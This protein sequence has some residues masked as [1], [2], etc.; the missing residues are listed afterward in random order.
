MNAI[1]QLGAS[2]SAIKMFYDTCDRSIGAIVAKKT[3]LIEPNI[4]QDESAIASDLTFLQ[5]A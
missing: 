3:N 4:G 1:N 2:A 5:L